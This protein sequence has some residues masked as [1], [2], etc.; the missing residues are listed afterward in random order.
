MRP[1]LCGLEG[2][3]LQD[4]RGDLGVECGETVGDALL[5]ASVG[6]GMRRVLKAEALTTV[7]RAPGTWSSTL[8]AI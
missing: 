7:L 1:C 3:D 8:H 4:L 5:F 2:V 6:K